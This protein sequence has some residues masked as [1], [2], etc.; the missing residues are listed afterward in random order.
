[1]GKEDDSEFIN[2]IIDKFK[3]L[4][5]QGEQF[6]NELAKNN[7]R[8]FMQIPMKWHG[9]NANK[10]KRISRPVG[11]KS[12]ISEDLK[13]LIA[14]TKGIFI[15]YEVNPSKEENNNKIK[16]TYVCKNLKIISQLEDEALPQA[17]E[18][19][20]N[21]AFYTTI[22]DAIRDIPLGDKTPQERTIYL[23]GSRGSGKTAFFNYFMS[24]HE[25][26][27]NKLHILTIRINVMRIESEKVTLENAIKFKLCK[28]LFKFYCSSLKKEELPGNPTIKNFIDPIL[29]SD[30]F[31]KFTEEEMLA[32]HNYF[33]SYPSKELINI[34]KEFSEICE[35]LMHEMSKSYKYIII[36]DNF[37][38][39]SPNE[40]S[41]N[42]YEIRKRQLKR[43]HNSPISNDGIF[44]ISV[45]YGTYKGLRPNGRQTPACWVIGYP[46]AYD[47]IMKRLNYHIENSKSD[48]NKKN[49]RKESVISCIRAIGSSFSFNYQEQ[50]GLLSIEDACT[51]I[52][53]I[54]EGNKR[55][56]LNMIV[57]Y[58]D[59]ILPFVVNLTE[60]N[61]ISNKYRFFESLLIN[62]ENGYCS[63]FYEYDLKDVKGSSE[64]VLTFAN[65]QSEAHHDNNYVPNLYS[66]PS[67]AAEVQM[68]FTPFLKIRILQLLYNN[69][70]AIS[71]KEII[72]VLNEIFSYRTDMIELACIELREDMSI[73]FN[74]ESR[75]ETVD[76]DERIKNIPVEITKRGENLLKILPTNVNLLS[77][78]LEKIFFPL[79]FLATGVPFGNYYTDNY[80]D[81]I[82]FIIKNKICSLP[83]I[84]GL[85]KSI[86]ESEKENF[87]E[88]TKNTPDYFKLH[89]D[90]CLDTAFADADFSL[91]S[92]LESNALD[93]I[94]DICSSY[95]GYI[96]E[97][98]ESNSIRR[99]RR[100]KLY[101]ELNRLLPDESE[102]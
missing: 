52:E 95:F 35:A 12:S 101:E 34:P 77:I 45:R 79:D 99:D 63:E 56:I 54:F 16:G 24:C 55:V 78:G 86:E 74:D 10:V 75:E 30:Q 44:L 96:S 80:L 41:K 8:S 33:V 51:Q 91:I 92:T 31:G 69:K 67:I 9:K 66:F 7:F 11:L 84:I 70:K 36:L 58:I 32:C 83:K 65:I 46:N 19:G 28:I 62:A 29:G 48:S 98:S 60:R 68:M 53:Q 17:N 40:R 18:N 26:D 82:D 50:S 93:S 14:F 59:S 4:V 64:S 90:V 72:N 20:V 37:D 2:D 22:V 6:G 1:M 23:T 57:R 13:D 94:K 100:T 88:K 43:I 61:L 89:T 25:N 71:T 85:F 21:D 87:I 47:M 38:M 39:L 102:A 81:S 15:H 73:I 97:N 42:E 76:N 27:L 5:I 49:L 3:K